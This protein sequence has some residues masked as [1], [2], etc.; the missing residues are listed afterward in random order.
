MSQEHRRITAI[1]GCAAFQKTCDD[2]GMTV[3]I[4][5]MRED[6]ANLNPSYLSRRTIAR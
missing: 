6:A 5:E 1:G 2:G 4:E 3:W